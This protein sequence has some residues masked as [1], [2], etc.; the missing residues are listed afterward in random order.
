MRIAV[1]HLITLT[2][3]LAAL[4]LVTGCS[5]GAPAT[6]G[7]QDAPAATPSGPPAST[8]APTAATSSAPSAAASSS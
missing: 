8:V 2:G 1:R 5:A 3:S 4:G 7:T 6:T